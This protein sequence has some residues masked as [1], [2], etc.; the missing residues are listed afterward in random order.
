MLSRHATTQ[1]FFVFFLS[2]RDQG[3]GMYRLPTI[4]K[5]EQVPANFQIVH[6]DLSVPTRAKTIWLFWVQLG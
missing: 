3:R 4:R 6:Y 2:F 1:S 5:F